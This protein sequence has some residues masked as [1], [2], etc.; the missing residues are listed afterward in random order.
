[1]LGALNVAGRAAHSACSYGGTIYVED[2]GLQETGA[3]NFREPGM[4]DANP[5]DV[6]T[7]LENQ[8][9]LPDLRSL[10][11]VFVG[12][13]DTAPPQIPLSISQQDN[14]I[15][16]WTA[17]GKASGAISVVIDPTPRNGI[18]APQNVP[19][20]LLV[21]VPAEPA[22][23]RSDQTFVFPDSGPVGFEPNSAVF[24]DPSAATA[25]LQPLARYLVANPSVK[26][27]LSGTTAHSGSFAFDLVL[28]LQRAD[29]VE[30]ILIQMG[31]NPAQILTRGLGWRFPGYENDQGPQWHSASRASRAQPLGDCQ[32]AVLDL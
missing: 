2:S 32:P 5:T 3:L 20:V 14:V 15:A 28:S 11:V 18:S 23:S 19:T 27:E 25:A 17:I 26:V 22:W 12:L 30:A 21:P 24:R 13:G 1:M 31:V 29:T 4:L 9:E 16:I 10:K 7:F 8:G 6:V